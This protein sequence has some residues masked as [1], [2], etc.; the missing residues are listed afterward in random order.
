MEIQREEEG[1]RKWGN[2]EHRGVGTQTKK[3][4]KTE[5][6]RKRVTESKGDSP[7]EHEPMGPGA[8]GRARWEARLQPSCWTQSA[9]N[10]PAD[11]D[12]GLTS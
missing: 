4:R 8:G 10:R 11:K 6:E 2:R 3:G 5:R 1:W 9:L 7:W 12:I